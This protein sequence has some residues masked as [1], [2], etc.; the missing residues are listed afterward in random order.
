M[1]LRRKT[2]VTISALAMTIGGGVLA[3]P[4]AAADEP[5]A[6]DKLCLYRS[7]LYRTMEFSTGSVSN[8]WWLWQYNL[9]GPP[10]SGI[11]SYRNN[12]SVKATLW[13]YNGDADWPAAPQATINSGGNSSNTSG[14]NPAF[15]DS[16]AVCTGNAKPWNIL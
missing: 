8:C 3:A 12:L 10:W 2:A 13:D 4:P 5:C 9:S 14:G 16:A 6:S 7:T 15:A 11:V 1:N